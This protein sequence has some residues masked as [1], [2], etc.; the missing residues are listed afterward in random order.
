MEE[1]TRGVVTPLWTI[2]VLLILVGGAL[3]YRIVAQRPRSVQFTSPYQAVLLSDGAV[4]YGKLDGY[5]TEHPVL[6]NVFYIVS[7]QNPE[8]KQVN[9][10]LVRRG[11][12]LHG[13]DRMYLNPRSIVFVEPVGPNSRVAQL[14]NEAP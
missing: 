5:G 11:K 10:V 1:R 3:S 2:V 7:Q 12:E 4:F 14:I 8:T 6:N 9:N 13:P